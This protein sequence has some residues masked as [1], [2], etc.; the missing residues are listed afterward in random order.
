MA[1]ITYATVYSEGLGDGEGSRQFEGA[2][3]AL[4]D[5]APRAVTHLIDGEPVAGGEPFER[6]DPTD[7]ARVIATAEAADAALVDRAVA[8]ARAAWPQWR[9]TP[10]ERRV[11]ILDQIAAA[12]DGR[13][14]ELAALVSHE[15]GKTRADAVAEVAECV[16]IANLYRDQ[17]LAADGYVVELKAPP[18][19][20]RAEV[21]LVPYGVFGVIAPFNF[22]LAISLGM[23][24]AALA[25]GD[26]VVFKP[27][28]LTPACGA[29]V[30]ELIA[31]T[32]LPAGAFQLV[33]GGAETG[34]ALADS[35]IDGLVFTG[36]AEVGLGLV[37]RL[38]QPPFIRPLIAEMGGK[39]PAIV[40]GSAPDLEV[41][42]R[43]VARSAFGMSG[44]KCN[45]CSRAVVTADAYDGF[46]DALVGEVAGLAVGDPIEAGSFT[47][48]VVGPRSVQRFER[49]V[50][51]ARADG[52]VIAGGGTGGPGH[53]AELTVVEGLPEGH[54]LTR[55]ELFL[56][57]LSLIRVADLD[58]AIAE[59]NAVRYGLSAGIFSADRGERER[60]QDEI[61]AGIT[62][63]SNPG[64]ATTGVW[65]GSQTMS[66][67]KGTGSAGKGGFGP[68]YLQQFARE[69]SRTIFA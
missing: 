45:A 23:A 68:W 11:E 32:D 4:R 35:A 61:E 33:N 13:L 55:E 63:L 53:Y 40:T 52:E 58:A 48:P 65:P 42:A 30:A 51:L 10:Y 17:I 47:G 43:A 2:L 14:V 41:A 21:A 1:A 59:A 24:L 49:A 26:T 19:A 50:E 62:F 12:I 39:N 9:R 36:S 7:P 38:S 56:P 34:Q 46:V 37:G 28:A 18:G 44:Q 60:F 8:A 25:M 6:N 20:D 69:Q 67:W 29:A 27:S 64:G 16:A 31:A 22:P 66:G 3:A 5:A 54:E 57:V 15:T